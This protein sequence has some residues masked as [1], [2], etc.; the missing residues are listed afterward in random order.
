MFFCVLSARTELG[1]FGTG[2]EKSVYF[3][4][5]DYQKKH[6]ELKRKET[7]VTGYFFSLVK[8]DQPLFYVPFSLREKQIQFTEAS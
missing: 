7:N 8:I 1:H 3:Q 2:L 5:I 4:S 6:T